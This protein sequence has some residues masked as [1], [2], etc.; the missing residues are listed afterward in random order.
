MST[1]RPYRLEWTGLEGVSGKQEL[2]GGQLTIGRASSCDLVLPDPLI[3]RE[4]ARIDADGSQLAIHD[5]GS[6]NGTL[7]NGERISS[8]DLHPG[9]EIN[10]GG[11]TLLL[12]APGWNATLTYQRSAEATVLLEP[13]APSAPVAPTPGVVSDD[14]LQQPIIS[15]RAL[16]AAGIEVKTAEYVALGGGLGSFIWVDFLRNSG[17]SANDIL[18]VGNEGQP[19][20]RYE[21]L[22]NNSQI[23]SRERLRS[24]SDS[25]PDNWRASFSAW[26]WGFPG[27]A[28]RE[29]WRELNQGNLK[30]ASAILWSITGEPALAQTYTPRSGDVFR[31]IEKEAQRINWSEMLN[32]G[33]IRAVRK[34]EEG[35]I[36]A[37]VSSSDE[38]RRQHFAVSGRFL[39]LALGYPAIQ[40]LPDLAD[41]REKYQDRVRVVN[42]YE[43]HDHV[44]T[45]L[46]Q[47]GGTVLVRGR[48]IVASRIIQRL[49]EERRRNPNIV[50]VHLHRSRTTV[51][52]R[53]GPARR[54]VK[55]QFELQPFNWP[56][57]CWGGE[58]RE[59]LEQA[60]EGK[61]KQLLDA[62]GGTITAN[63][64]DWQ[65]IVQDGTRQGWYR[66]E[67]G[68]VKDVRPGKDGGVLTQISSILHGG[69]TRELAADFIIDCTGAV[70]SPDRSSPM[71]DLISTYSLPRNILGRL[72]VH[73]DFE[74]SN[75]RYGSCRVYAAGV[76]T[77]GGPHAAVDSFLGLQFAAL[78]SVDSI[79]GL[80]PRPKGLRRLDGLYSF[81]QWLKWAQG[82]AP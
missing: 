14:V 67:Y 4:H 56:K 60:S 80:E 34:S 38:R 1:H 12:I 61:R 18:V 31:S 10:L 75:M 40:L 77:L 53:Y 32:V 74:V 48:G 39:H 2:S 42:A 30:E 37:V 25:C 41:Y 19:H 22:C 71:A 57:S 54:A 20:A 76:T 5:L 63:R 7:V 15:E 9:D 46:G 62:W 8:A 78:R 13:Q 82:V 73:N 24:S 44:Y 72:Q 3:S 27:Y 65:R 36:L 43:P 66:S 28:V 29:I 64:Q 47:H 50:I 69:G 79:C 35:R 59:A 17:V 51:G 49:W 6:R 16:A 26:I 55:E 68:V 70:S 81:Q 11:T 33:R 21:R 52:H 58:L 45:Q 23:P